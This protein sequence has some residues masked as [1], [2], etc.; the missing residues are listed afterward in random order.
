M[1]TSET[2]RDKEHMNNEDEILITA[3]VSVAGSRYQAAQLCRDTA[4]K[5]MDDEKA[6]YI[7]E[8]RRRADV[9]ESATRELVALGAVGRPRKSVDRKRKAKA[10]APAT[11]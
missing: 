4:Q 3:S 6:N 11:A 7:I 5:I 8:L 9:Y 2:N 10:E 1:T